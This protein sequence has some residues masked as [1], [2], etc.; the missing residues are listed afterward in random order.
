MIPPPNLRQQAR[1]CLRLAE[2]C[3]DHHLSQRL[4]AMASD[5]ATKADQYDEELRR[6]VDHL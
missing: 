1:V 3:D 2:Y 5:L 6:I 4:I